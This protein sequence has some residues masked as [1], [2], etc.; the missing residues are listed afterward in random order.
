M[1]KNEFQNLLKASKFPNFF[2]FFGNDEYQIEMFA[3]EALL[4]FNNEN[5]LN[6]YFDEYNFIVAKSH[7]CEPSLFYTSNLLHLKTDKKIP[8]KELKELINLCKKNRSNMFIYEL[9]E[10]DVK[11]IFDTQKA[12]ESNFVRLFSPDNIDEALNLLAYHAKKLNLNITRTALYKIYTLQN[13][14]LYLSSSELN[15]LSNLAQ[16]IDENMVDQ[17]VF[18]LN[19]ISFELFFNKIITTRNIKDY[20][21]AYRDGSNF[22]EIFIIN[23]LYKSFFRLFKINTYAKIYGKFNLKEALGYSPPINIAKELKEHATSISTNLY[24]KIFIKL[25]L[26]E[27]ELKTKKDIDKDCF[28]L[29][30]ILSLQN[31]IVKNRKN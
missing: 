17:L 6:L 24:K 8:S 25:N 4:K 26:M 23:S 11:M 21:F 14:S 29:S 9:Y 31:L 5:I 7:L 13:E 3:K 15:K 18:S 30:S 2:L 19:G 16:N 20:Y 1:Y 12:F 27:Y 10:S 22:D 28:L